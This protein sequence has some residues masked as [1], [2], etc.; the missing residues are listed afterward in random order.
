MKMDVFV[1]RL[2]HLNKTWKTLPPDYGNAN[3][4]DL[5]VFFGAIS[6]ITFMA[7]IMQRI[8]LFDFAPY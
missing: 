7:S 6:F 3:I 4:N 1:K 2:K 5:T 8:S